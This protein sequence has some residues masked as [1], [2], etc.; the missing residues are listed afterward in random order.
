MP[1]FTREFNP[2]SQ[3]GCYFLTEESSA[4]LQMTQKP[5]IL[6][7]NPVDK[8]TSLDF[9]HHEKEMASISNSGGQRIGD[10]LCQCRAA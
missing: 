2:Y 3:V 5:A 10:Q 1:H 7:N 9:F 4:E 8:P 6:I